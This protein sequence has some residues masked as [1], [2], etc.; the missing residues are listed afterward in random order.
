MHAE[1]ICDGGRA[2][3]YGHLALI[4][5]MKWRRFALPFQVRTENSCGVRSTLHRD[6]RD[7]G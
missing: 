5:I 7:A 4:E 1:N 2:P 6:L 3:D